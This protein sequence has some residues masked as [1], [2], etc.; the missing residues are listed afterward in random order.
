MWINRRYMNMFMWYI[1]FICP[2]PL[3]FNEARA[4]VVMM[5]HY[6]LNL[7]IQ[8]TK[9][10]STNFKHRTDYESYIYQNPNIVEFAISKSV[11]PSFYK[12]VAIFKGKN[13]WYLSHRIFG[14]GFSLPPPPLYLSIKNETKPIY[15]FWL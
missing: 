8:I 7:E 13:V 12:Y 15:R 11:F 3:R 1:A 4:P 9:D 5:V 10:A 2:F 6:P 14:P